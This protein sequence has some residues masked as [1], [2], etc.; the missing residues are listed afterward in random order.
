QAFGK[1]TSVVSKTTNERQSITQNGYTLTVQPNQAITITKIDM[2]RINGMMAGMQ[3]GAGKSGGASS[4]PNESSPAA[5]AVASSNSSQAPADVKPATPG[6]VLGNSGSLLLPGTSSGSLLQSANTSTQAAAQTI[7][8]GSTTTAAATVVNSVFASFGSGQFNFVATAPFLRGLNNGSSTSPN[9]T[10]PLSS[11]IG[12][13]TYSGFSS[14]IGPGSGSPF[15]NAIDRA[16]GDASRNFVFDAANGFDLSV[17]FNRTFART[18]TGGSPLYNYTFS[19]QISRQLTGGT[20]AE[21]GGDDQVKFIRV[22]GPSIRFSGTSTITASGSNLPAGLTAGTTTTSFGPETITFPLSQSLHFIAGVPATALPGNGQFSYQLIGA[23]SP[24]FTDGS[25]SP[26]KL[27]GTMSVLFGSVP[28]RFYTNSSGQP[29]FTS[30]SAS[31]PGFTVGL[32]LSVAM[33]GDATY[34]I[35]T[36]GGAGNPSAQISQFSGTQGVVISQGPFGQPERFSGN[37]IIIAPAGSRAC[38][39]GGSSCSGNVLGVLLGTNATRAAL[40]YYIGAF[41][42]STPGIN[43]VAA[44]RR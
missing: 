15:F 16:T 42:G 38:P 18:T 12:G 29:I 31:I 35:T 27:T 11:T 33:P 22:A 4:V 36:I 28:S 39:N 9:V 30:Y 25:G 7:V 40:A 34:Q 6:S 21:F 24:T 23:T 1:D 3:G 10:F 26:G 13:G 41:Q 20:L 44:F 5:S 37:P 32:D 2:G 19:F 43:G 17:N 8:V 14:T